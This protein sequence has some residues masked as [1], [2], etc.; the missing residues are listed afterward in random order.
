MV[1]GPFTEKANNIGP[2]AQLALGHDLALLEVV[3]DADRTCR[4]LRGLLLADAPNGRLDAL[5]VG[6]GKAAC[7]LKEAR[8]S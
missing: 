8:I 5:A 1:G 3:R 6:L 2:D 7:A 4:S